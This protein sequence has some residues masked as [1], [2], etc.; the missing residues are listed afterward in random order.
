[1]TEDPSIK[2]QHPFRKRCRCC[3]KRFTP[4]HR[5]GNQQTHCPALACQA[6]RQRKNE[7]SWRKKNPEAVALQ[8]KKWQKNNPK[9]WFKWRQKHPGYVRRNKEFMR[10][11]MRRRRKAARFV[12]SKEMKL[13]LASIKGVAHEKWYMPRGS[14]WLILR[15]ERASRLSKLGSLGHTSG[16]EYRWPRG[17][18]YD[19]SPALRKQR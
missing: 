19:V 6:K 4:D 10:L 2:K 12:K 18:L 8:C 7:R 13:Q 9:Y 3:K 5:V 15:L 1:M 16:V 17:R 11:Y 14:R